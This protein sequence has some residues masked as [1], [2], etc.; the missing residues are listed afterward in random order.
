LSS[1]YL[2]G[3][4]AGSRAA[5]GTPLL[6]TKHI[7]QELLSKLRSLNDI[8]RA[9]G[10][11]LAQLALAWVLRDPRMTSAIVGVSSVE[12]LHENLAALRNCTISPEEIAAIDLVLQST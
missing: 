11:S 9:R 2:D 5:R 6:S 4:P 8:A 3:I 7:S 12:Q 1:R 10:Q